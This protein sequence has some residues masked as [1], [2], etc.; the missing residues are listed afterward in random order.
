[1]LAAGGERDMASTDA[2]ADSSAGGNRTGVYLAVLQLIF[3]L[4]WTIY[5]IYLPKLAAQV[6]IAPGTVIPLLLPAQAVFTLSDAGMGLVA[7]KM[8]RFVG[9][10]GIFV[11]VLS[12][13]ACA[14]FVALA[15]V[16]GT[17]P[18][19]QFWFIAV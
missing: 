5:V 12:V 6:G 7:D 3:T 9:R 15:F 8:A 19:A 16:A 18:G 10:L 2:T 11:G 17:G 14:A 13:I 4:G 1:M